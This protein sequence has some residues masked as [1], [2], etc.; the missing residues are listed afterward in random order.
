EMQVGVDDQVDVGRAHIQLGQRVGDR[1]VDHAPVVQHGRRAAD[2]GVDQDRTARMGDHE[3][4]HRPA[5]AVHA[6]QAG[7]V[8]PPDLQRHLFSRPGAHGYA[9]GVFDLRLGRLRESAWLRAGLLVV[10]VGLAVYGLASQW[11]EV[12]A[13]LD[14]LDA[15]DIAGAT[16]SAVA[17]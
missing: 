6:L 12:Q 9:S 15:A 3:P 16:V 4:V 8:Q 10:A 7:Q 17:G 5:A 13:A 2:P 1:R 14:R 11:T